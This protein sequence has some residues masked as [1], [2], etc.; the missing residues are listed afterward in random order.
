MVGWHLLEGSRYDEEDRL[1]ELLLHNDW[2]VRRLSN[3]RLRRESFD[4]WRFCLNSK[5]LPSLNEVPQASTCDN[6]P[7]EKVH[8]LFCSQ[9]IHST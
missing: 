4:L 5:R 9:L 8:A 2:L 3:Q 6:I 7:Y 1:V